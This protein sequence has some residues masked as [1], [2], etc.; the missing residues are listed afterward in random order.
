MP[1][2]VSATPLMSADLD[3]LADQVIAVLPFPYNY[4]PKRMIV[5]ALTHIVQFV[6]A[7]LVQVLISAIDG[8]SEAEIQTAGDL[9]TREVVDYI[10]IPMIPEHV[11]WQIIHPVVV[12]LLSYAV[13]GRSITLWRPEV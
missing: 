4:V 13:D 5:S 9:I 1:R 6:P 12:A 7:D 2:N 11:E 3:H 10:D 8:L